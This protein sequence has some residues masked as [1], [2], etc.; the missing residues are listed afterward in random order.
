M[1]TKLTL[2]HCFR[3][4]NSQRDDDNKNNAKGRRHSHGTNIEN[5]PPFSHLPRGSGVFTDP[6]IKITKAT[7]REKSI[8]EIKREYNQL[9]CQFYQIYHPATEK[10]LQVYQGN[11]S[12]GVSEDTTNFS[13]KSFIIKTK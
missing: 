6:I 10:N 2:I 1:Y 7:K 5:L 13:S 3:A 11:N 9:G 8:E 12:I 4:R